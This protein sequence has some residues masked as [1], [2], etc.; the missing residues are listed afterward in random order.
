M[1]RLRPT[2]RLTAKRFGTV[3]CGGDG[4]CPDGTECE[5]GV[6]IDGY[7]Q[8]V[9]DDYTVVDDR[10]VRYHSD[11]TELTRTEAG[12]DVI[13]NPAVVGRA[14]LLT[15]LQAGD[16]VTLKPITDGYQ[17]YDDLEITGSPLPAYGRR[18]RPTAAHIELETA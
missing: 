16:S 17:T 12:E 13:D 8:P 3:E 15:E 5:N 4:D 2:H 7:G 6:C 18:S 1:P 14:E 10:P 11:G 9:E